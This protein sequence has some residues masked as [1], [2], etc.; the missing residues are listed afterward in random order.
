MK[1]SVQIMSL[2]FI[3]YS[4]SANTNFRQFLNAVSVEDNGSAVYITYPSQSE[5]VAVNTILQNFKVEKINTSEYEV[6]INLT[7]LNMASTDLNM[8]NS[9]EYNKLI[10]LVRTSVLKGFFRFQSQDLMQKFVETQLIPSIGKQVY[11][12][13]KVIPGG[14][15]LSLGRERSSGDKGIIL[16]DLIVPLSIHKLEVK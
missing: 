11:V 3:A 16:S 10:K 6:S 8:N 12:E 5:K 2:M 1:M 14:Y 9:T 13:G 15:S 4:A 7:Q